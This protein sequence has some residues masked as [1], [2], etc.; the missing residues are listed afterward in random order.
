MQNKVDALAGFI[1]ENGHFC[2][3]LENVA[4]KD[5]DGWKENCEKCK[6][7]VIENCKSLG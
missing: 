2:P 4:V 1:V 3:V 7:C 5:C 6:K